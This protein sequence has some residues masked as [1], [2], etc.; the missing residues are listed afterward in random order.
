MPGRIRPVVGSH[1]DCTVWQVLSVAVSVRLSWD[2]VAWAVTVK[3]Q[4]TCP[5]SPGRAACH[6]PATGSIQTAM[7]CVTRTL[8]S[9]PN[10]GGIDVGEPTD[11]HPSVN[12]RV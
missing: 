3:V 6:G 7:C 9:T 12:K 8:R 11:P 2:V 4:S 10:P 1:P 5:G